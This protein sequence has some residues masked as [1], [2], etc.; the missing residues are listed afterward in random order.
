M[1]NASI[2]RKMAILIRAQLTAWVVTALLLLLMALLLF[3]LEL[4]ESKVSLGMTAVY[5]LSCFFGGLAAGKGGKKKKFLWGLLTGAV[6]FLVLFLLESGSREGWFSLADTDRST[7]LGRRDA[8]R[9]DFLSGK[10]RGVREK[11]SALLENTGGF[12]KKDMIYLNC[13]YDFKSI[14]TR[15]PEFMYPYF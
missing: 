6:Y 4:N 5:V 1:E 3:K 12:L 7:L 11:S 9:N 8:G 10:N 14:L 15:N 2:G 13:F